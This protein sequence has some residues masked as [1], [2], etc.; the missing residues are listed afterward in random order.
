MSISCDF[1]EHLRGFERSPNYTHNKYVSNSK[2]FLYLHG[3]RIM[4]IL[5]HSWTTVKLQEPRTILQYNFG[6]TALVTIKLL[7]SQSTV[8]QF[9]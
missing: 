3:V 8:I 2:I 5:K 6:C 1:Y 7:D 9:L 4:D